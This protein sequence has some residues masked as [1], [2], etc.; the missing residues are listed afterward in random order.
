[1]VL[2]HDKVNK[3]VGGWYLQYQDGEVLTENDLP[4]SLVPNKKNIKLMGLKWR[5]KHFEIQDKLAYLPP[6]ETQMKELSVAG[7]SLRTVS[8]VVGRFIGFYTDTEKVI[9]RVD[10]N[11]GQFT[12][13]KVPY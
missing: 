6:G 4:W 2:T 1:M 12:E 7:K 10:I 8:L 11:S 13:E 5:H 9:I 3:L